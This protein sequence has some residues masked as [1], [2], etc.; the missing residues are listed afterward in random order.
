M[1]PETRISPRERLVLTSIIEHYIETGDPVSSQAVA[2]DFAH[3]NGMSSA[4]IRNVMASLAENGLLEQPHTSAGRIPTPRAFRYYV[5]HLGAVGALAGH[6]VGAP[7]G[8]QP[9]ALSDN[10]REQIDES[11]SGVH[12][13]QQFLERTSH[14]LALLSSGVGIAFA[15]LRETHALEHIHFSRLAPNRVLAV[16]VTV[17]GVVLDRMLLLDHDLSSAELEVSSRFLN[18]NFH[19]W[20]IDSIRTELNTRLES[21]RN[22]YDRLM[23]SLR[24]LHRK[25]ALDNAAEPVIFVEGVGNLLDHE[26]DR[27]RLRAM[28][29]AL[30]TKQRLI[31]LLTAYLDARQKNVRVVVGLEEAM[32]EMENLVLIGAPARVG[33]ESMGTVAVLAPTRIHYQETIGAVSY[34]AQLSARLLQPPQ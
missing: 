13:S 8:Q 18:E 28:L 6:I 15:A 27:D 31:E 19:G 16:V 29:A 1:A 20:P 9:V 11:F 32:P 25:G 4:T 5:E 22:E 33:E 24:E 12:T 30:E 23:Q 14:V 7:L 3:R 21:E 34:I 10:R 26:A 2:R 17:S